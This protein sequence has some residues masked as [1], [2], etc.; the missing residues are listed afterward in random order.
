MRDF[1]HQDA[2][3]DMNSRLPDYTQPFLAVC[4]TFVDAKIPYGR[5][6]CLC[7]CA[8]KYYSEMQKDQNSNSFPIHGHIYDMGAS[9]LLE[10][11][12]IDSGKAH[13]LVA[14]LGLAL[15]AA[16]KAASDCGGS[17][18]FHAAH[19][20]AQVARL[21]YDSNTLWF[22]YI[23]DGLSDLPCKALLNLQPP[24]EHLGDAGKLRKPDDGIGWHV[25]NLHLQE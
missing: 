22:E 5:K 2:C 15:E 6:T 14:H 18:L 16:E 11:R 10:S 12:T 17:C 8:F 9:K 24:R 13:E 4:S 21:R 25:A 20:H 3:G 1:R 23:H 7:L 19:H